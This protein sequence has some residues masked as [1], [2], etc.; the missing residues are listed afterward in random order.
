MLDNI[1]IKGFRFLDGLNLRGANKFNLIVGPNNSGKTS[2]LEALF[3]HCAPLNCNML[4]TLLSFRN[5]GFLPN[6]AYVFDRFKWFFTDPQ[7]QST[8]KFNISG[9]WNI[10]QRKTEVSFVDR[11]VHQEG[12]ST[13]TNGVITT[14][15]VDPALIKDNDQEGIE[16][17]GIS[18]G[19][20]NFLF[21]SS[22]QKRI[23]QSFEFTSK[24]PLRID[25]PKIRTDV[26]A[27]YTD[28]FGH[29]NPEGGLGDYNKAAKEGHDKKCL[30]LMSKLDPEIENI[31]ILLAPNNVPELFVTHKSLG[32]TPISNLGDGLRRIFIV[33]TAMSRCKGGVF[34]VDELENSV[35]PSALA[36]FIN[37]IFDIAKE[38]NIQIFTTT[39]SLEAI[40]AVLGS[41]IISEDDLSL[42][43]LKSDDKKIACKKISGKT[44]KDLRYELAQDVRL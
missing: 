8:G 9:T 26:P 16:K 27:V 1:S 19:T 13:K 30:E 39:H 17:E 29:R 4:L 22:K 34:L 7:S 15:T 3:I 42:F 36:E 20:I 25:G 14:S 44:L 6:Q 18:I 12:T 24:G 5:G 38:L 41:K 10:V 31:S 11:S 32:K 2:L 23:K 28:P 33:S 43:R 37:W 35:H 40:D 21:E